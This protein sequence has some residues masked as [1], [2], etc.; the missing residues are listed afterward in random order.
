MKRVAL[1]VLAAMVLAGS[2]W[3]DIPPYP[4]DS[5]PKAAEEESNSTGTVAAGLALAAALGI[6][7]ALA[8]KKLKESDDQ[9]KSEDMKPAPAEAK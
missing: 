7:G 6:G 5:K 2:V 9:P 8:I 3:A 4:R 1:S